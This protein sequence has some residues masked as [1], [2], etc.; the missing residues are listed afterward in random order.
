MQDSKGAFSPNQQGDNVNEASDMV[1]LDAS[2]VIAIP[3]GQQPPNIDRLPQAYA[4][5]ESRAAS[6]FVGNPHHSASILGIGERDQVAFF[7]AYPTPDTSGEHD[8]R[9]ARAATERG[10]QAAA[11][12]IDDIRRHNR[13]IPHIN[14][15]EVETVRVANQNAV[16]TNI[17]EETG[18]I[19]TTRYAEKL[20][21]P[22][23]TTTASQQPPRKAAPGYYEGTFGKPYETS[24]Y[25]TR[26]Y[27]TMPYDTMEYKSVYDP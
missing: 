3:E 12:E 22:T 17:L 10:R 21:K 26:E 2:Q 11:S 9:M 7:P 24:E 6:T 14:A 19:Q 25:D 8:R 13:I 20:S 1:W 4:E 27:D 18:Q 23:N 15:Y 16:Y 5:A